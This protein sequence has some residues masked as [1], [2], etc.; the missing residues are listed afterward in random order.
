MTGSPAADERHRILVLTSTFP[1]W[2]DDHMPAFVHGLCVELGK[3]YELHVLAPHT[4]GD[5][6]IEEM[7]GVTVHRFRYGWPAVCERVA[8]G[9]GMR[10][11]LARSWFARFTFPMFVAAELIA[12]RQL[13]RSLRPQVIHSHWLIPQGFVGMLLKRTVLRDIPH[14]VTVHAADFYALR[15]T[16]AGRTILRSVLKGTD[17]VISVSRAILTDMETIAGRPFMACVSPMGVSREAFAPATI[18]RDSTNALRLLFV[19]RFVEKK[20]LPFLVEAFAQA[21]ARGCDATLTLVGDGPERPHIEK[22]VARL[23]VSAHITFAGAVSARDVAASMRDADCLVVPSI[24]DARGETEGMPVVILEAFA[25]GVPVIASRVSGIPD[26]VEDNRAGLLVAPGDSAALA[27]AII[28]IAA[29]GV[30]ARLAE[31]ARAAAPAYEWSVIAARHR[32]LY[33]ELIATSP[34]QESTQC[35][36]S[37]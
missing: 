27:D 37:C 2:P 6:R 8:Y 21:R 9:S 20:G 18:A 33:G 13:V 1:R 10:E 22:Q 11:N 35:A 32:Q 25:A 31:G 12:T 14:V 17:A 4:P 34:A 29:P 15:Q 36:S 5:E 7:D 23:G 26:V 30:R 19:G 28:Q 24:V 3:F 16:A